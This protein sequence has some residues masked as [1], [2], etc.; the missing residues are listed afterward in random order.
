M[1]QLLIK[2]YKQWDT[3][4]IASVSGLSLEKDLS[5][6]RE[7]KTILETF[8]LERGLVLFCIMT[9]FTHQD[10]RGFQRELLLL[11]EQA[12][13]VTELIKDD[14]QLELTSES[15]EKIFLQRNLSASRKQVYPCL[16]RA[17]RIVKEEI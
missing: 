5:L 16:S 11:G 7:F 4:G 8:S 9:A 15:P 1:N 17:L 12:D 6:R 10:S 3:L 2:D 13:R 14:L